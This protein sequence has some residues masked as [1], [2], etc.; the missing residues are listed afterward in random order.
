MIFQNDIINRLYF[1]VSILCVN[2]IEQYICSVLMYYMI[3]W[4]VYIM[5]YIIYNIYIYINIK[6]TLIWLL[7][8]I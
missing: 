7:N 8:L 5:E 4:N 3:F 2:T 1:N 6:S